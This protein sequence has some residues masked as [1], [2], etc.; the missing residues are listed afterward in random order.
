MTGFIIGLWVGL[1]AGEVV[2]FWLTFAKRSPVVTVDPWWLENEDR[3]A[4]LRPLL[5]AER[6]EELSGSPVEETP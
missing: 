1:L 2:I 4:S 5:L 6:Q 3:W